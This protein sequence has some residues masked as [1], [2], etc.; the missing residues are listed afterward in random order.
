MSFSWSFSRLRNFETCAK[1]HY[2]YDVAKDVGDTNNTPVLLAG[3]ALHKAF[4]L[5][6]RNGTKLPLDMTQHEPL[7]ARLVDAP[8]ETY[9][10]QDLALTDK[11]K[12]TG[13][14]SKAAWFRAKLDFTKVNGA[15]ATVLDWKTGKVASEP[16][17]L[18]LQAVTIMHYLPEIKTVK[19]AFMFVNHD[20]VIPSIFTRN[21]VPQIW[22]GILP[23]V[24]KLEAAYD[25]QEFPAQPNGLCKRYCQVTSCPYHGEGS[26]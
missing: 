19:S 18:E 3:H 12:P 11:F 13:W 26:M 8:G 24:R 16:T 22:G 21:D 23:R 6:V 20:K 17:Q 9:A 25:N 2:H 4:E 5:R 1:R 7:L 10:E 14:R 15:L